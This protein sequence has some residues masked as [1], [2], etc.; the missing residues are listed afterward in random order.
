MAEII[1]FKYYKDILDF[2]PY[3]RPKYIPL[4]DRTAIVNELVAFF[5]KERNYTLPEDKPYNQK[6]RILRGLL[7]IRPPKAIPQ[8]LIIIQDMLLWSETLDKEIVDI[9]DFNYIDGIALWQGDITR[10]N[11]DA[12]VNA[13][14]N[15]MLGCFEPEHHCIDNAIHSAGGLQIREDCAK[16]MRLQNKE[17]PTG[18]AK[19]TLAYNLPSTFV[20]HTVGPIVY[21]GVTE[22]EKIKLASCYTACLNLAAEVGLKS[23]VFCCISTGEF[24]F[25]NDEA[26]YI[27]IKTVRNWLQKNNTMRV[28]FNVFLDKDRV[29]Y[30]RQL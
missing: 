12:I 26:C 29:L 13:A 25:P 1:A 15:D 6:R 28:I 14:N 20:L 27:A 22:K 8:E 9:N 3:H 7:N 5:A 17:E 4:S 2:K 21:S 11:A 19:I 10:L 24:R 16:I 18:I 30:E 23:I